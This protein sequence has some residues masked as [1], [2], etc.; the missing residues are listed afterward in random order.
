LSWADGDQFYSVLALAKGGGSVVRINI[1]NDNGTPKWYVGNGSDSGSN[2]A[3]TPFECALDTVHDVVCYYKRATAEFA[4]D[5][6][7]KVWVDNVLV[8]DV[9]DADN[10][11]TTYECDTVRTGNT[12]K[13]GTP[14]G[15]TYTDNIKLGTT[16][17]A[18][19]I[20]PS[21]AVDSPAHA[22]ATSM[23]ESIILELIKAQSLSE[24]TTMA[25]QV[26]L[27][28]GRDH[29]ETESVGM[30]ELFKVAL[31]PPPSKAFMSFMIG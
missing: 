27:S 21:M 30:V 6:I 26:T 18:G 13:T 16:G 11:S 8:H 24:T 31:I 3:I 25:E 2:D 23:V 5:G 1:H 10:W 17:S 9:E 4:L 22:D 20:G 15:I 29:Q 28:M 7:A 19:S 14:N 12:Y